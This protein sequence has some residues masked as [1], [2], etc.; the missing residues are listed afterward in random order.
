MRIV[1]LDLTRY[2][3]FTDHSIC[4]GERTGD[5]P[6]LHVIYGPNEAGKSTTH[7]A[8]LDLLFGIDG[9]SRYN[10]LH[11][12][13]T[14]RIGG[15]IEIDGAAHEFVRTKRPQNSLLDGGGNPISDRAILGELGGI[16]RASYTTMFSLDDDTLEKG[17]DSILASKGDLGQL[18][19]AASSGLSD[20][21][22]KLVD[23]GVE[24]DGFYKIRGRGGELA[25]LKAQLADLKSR[26]EA[27]DTVATAYAKLVDERD[28]AGAQYDEAMVARGVIQSRLEELRRQREALPKLGRLRELRVRAEP[29][30]AIPDAPAGWAEELPG[31]QRDETELVTRADGVE[32]EIEKISAELA[33]IAVDDRI[34]RFAGRIDRLAFLRAQ[35]LAAEKEI[36]DER[37]RQRGAELAIVG[38]L[39][40]MECDPEI[41]PDNLL[42]GASTTGALR[43]L[44]ERWSAVEAGVETAEGELAAARQRLD[45]SQ[46]KLKTAGGEEQA[47]SPFAL[48]QLSTAVA[49]ARKDDHA[50]RRRFAERARDE[51]SEAL[52]LH[53]KALRPWTGEATELSDLVV[54]GV[55]DIERWKSSTL[56]AEKRVERHG[57]TMTQLLVEQRHLTADIDAADGVAGV[58][59]DQDAAKIRAARE[60]AWASHKRT[61]DAA[62]ADTFEAILRRDDIVTGSRLAKADE[63]AKLHQ[64]SK[65][66]ASVN[67]DLTAARADRAAAAEEVEA[68][69]AEIAAAIRAMAP[70]LPQDWIL[71]K[72]EAWLENRKKALEALTAVRKAEREL[73]EAEQDE[74][75]VRRRL[76]DAAR[77]ASVDFPENASTDL[78]VSLV[79]TVIDRETELK[80]LRSDVAD[81]KRDLEAREHKALTAKNAAQEWDDKWARLCAGCWLGKAGSIPAVATVREVLKALDELGPLIEKRTGSADRLQK[82]ESDR[83]HFVTEVEALAKALDVDV[84]CPPLDTAAQ[85]L[86]AVKNARAAETERDG[87]WKRL[88]EAEER[89]DRIAEAKDVHDRRKREMTRHF[90]VGSLTD[91]A[92]K[93]HALE[94]RKGLQDQAAIA[95]RDILDA[96]GLASIEAAERLL[97]GLDRKAVET[98]MAELTGRSA[99]QDKRTQELFSERSKAADRLEAVG[100][101]D[102]VARIE[103]RRRTTL[104]EIEEKAKHYL[105]LRLGVA[106]AEQALRMYRDRHRSSMMAR[107]S[108]AF[109]IISRGAYK[110]LTTQPDKGNDVLVAVGANDGS[111]VASDLSKGTRF[112]L[113]LA[114]RVAGYQEFVRSRRSIPFI[115]DDIMETF[116]DFRAEEAFKLLAEMARVGQV[117]YLTH[118]RHLCDI[119]RSACP[120]VRIHE[121]GDIDGS[122]SRMAVPLKAVGRG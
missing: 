110:G 78:I 84:G 37:L 54:P 7:T 70:A 11:P 28:R 86:E 68:L 4:F 35:H 76:T 61:L 122:L 71:A 87:A 25:D 111:K 38:V 103:T 33:G 100:G 92:A 85:L 49:L 43:E 109:K 119:A 34:L 89:R 18:L 98:E 80:G 105:R 45:E 15:A 48:Q 31:R 108:E 90:G 19:F 27:V 106:A 58:V 24:A 44:M 10:F 5:G 1:R 112:Q 60:E 6:D 46:A 55:E 62:S 56:A 32:R 63:V 83:H 36:P 51:Q 39:K 16:D 59:S 104:L 88:K 17:G 118:H 23:L 115:A 50:V 96:L 121:L 75:T 73:R 102:A 97:D 116:D 22:Q 9:R 77:A 13:P 69:Q 81:R 41:E 21:T 91:V 26:R 113:Y 67:R 72:L 30:A 53:M 120:E 20:L 93:L 82:L 8:Y 14:M 65:R 52:S 2:G 99:D 114:L 66:L 47:D 57:E 107:A 101:D 64:T 79:Q 74:E 40:R 3:I 42:L 117:I 95:E 94:T 12:Y 29:L